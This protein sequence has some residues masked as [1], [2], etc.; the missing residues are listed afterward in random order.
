MK[1]L[2]KELLERGKYLETLPDSDEKTF[3]IRENVLTTV[4]IQQ[5]LLTNLTSK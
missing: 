2:Y 3:R 1:E 5:I 4:R